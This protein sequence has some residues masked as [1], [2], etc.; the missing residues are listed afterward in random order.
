[1]TL[2]WTVH[3]WVDREI[4]TYLTFQIDGDL[5]RICVNW[6]VPDSPIWTTV[7]SVDLLCH[8]LLCG[9]GIILHRDGIDYELLCPALSPLTSHRRVFVWFSGPLHMLT[10]SVHAGDTAFLLHD[11]DPGLSD[12]DLDPDCLLVYLFLA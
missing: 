11:L 12:L 6:I 1:M 2:Q 8:G 10:Q 5:Y 3:M 7:C 9:P 4:L